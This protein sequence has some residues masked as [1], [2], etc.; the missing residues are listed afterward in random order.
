MGTRS[1][2]V[3][4]FG[5]VACGFALTVALG[6]GD[7]GNG[8]D[9][10]GDGATTVVTA[11]A[12]G[13][14]TAP[15]TGDVD[16]TTVQMPGCEMVVEVCEAGQCSCLCADPVGTSDDGGGGECPPVLPAGAC[17][18]ACQAP[19]ASCGSADSCCG[20]EPHEAGSAYWVCSGVSSPGC[21]DE[22]PALGDPCPVS[23]QCWY[24]DPAF[25]FRMCDG[26]QWTEIA[27]WTCP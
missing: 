17:E 19:Q 5:R 3:S 22:V 10:G 21:P 9:S 11:S 12:D 20:C 4:I 7:D 13:S 6:C 24:C 18:V 15:T 23:L 14:A 27:E 8:E 26:T 25:A 2:S 1:R 16:C